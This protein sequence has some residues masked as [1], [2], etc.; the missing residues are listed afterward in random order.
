[1]GS[2]LTKRMNHYQCNAP[3]FE[4]AE[5]A[6]HISIIHDVDTTTRSE[7]LAS[8]ERRIKGLEGH[9]LEPLFL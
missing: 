5:L 6:N 9:H 7:Y 8:L 1:M 2:L 3:K 4:E